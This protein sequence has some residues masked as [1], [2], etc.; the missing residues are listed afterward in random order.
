MEIESNIPNSP[1]PGD[2]FFVRMNN[3][4]I[5]ELWLLLFLLTMR[6]FL[7]AAEI[8]ET[9]AVDGTDQQEYFVH[10]LNCK[11]RFYI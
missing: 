9:R 6:W 10:Y 3:G 4:S 11:L 2:T 8:L 1:K 5:R 7:D